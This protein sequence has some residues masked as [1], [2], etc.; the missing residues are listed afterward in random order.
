MFHIGGRQVLTGPAAQHAGHLRHFLR[1]L[2]DDGIHTVGIECIKP[3]FTDG[4]GPGPARTAQTPGTAPGEN[5]QEVLV[6]APDERISPGAMHMPEKNSHGCRTFR[7]VDS[8]VTPLMS[9]STASTS[10]SGA[11]DDR[12]GCPATG[13]S[14][15]RLSLQGAVWSPRISSGTP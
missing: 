13:H 9:R 3:Y 12:Q 4:G 10:C 1:T 2:Q 6:G 8:E 11:T 7:R 5:R 15:A 14:V